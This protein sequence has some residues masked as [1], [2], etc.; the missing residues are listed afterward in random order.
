MALD[1]GL[2][3]HRRVPQCP[4]GARGKLVLGEGVGGVVTRR[5]M[6]FIRSQEGGMI[7]SVRLPGTTS[8]SS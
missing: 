2:L 6:I 1:I 7:H 4:E 8:R 5:V 3:W